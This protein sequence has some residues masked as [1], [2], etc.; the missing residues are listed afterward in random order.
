MS[1]LIIFSD[2]HHDGL[3]YSLRLLAKRLNADIYFPIGLTWWQKGFWD[4]V[5]VNGKALNGK[6]LTKDIAEKF[7]ADLEK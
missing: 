3:A 1:K 4:V 7:K 5:D 2:R 6:P